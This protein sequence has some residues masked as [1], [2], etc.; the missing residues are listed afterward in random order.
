MNREELITQIKAF[1]QI[2]LIIL[3]RNARPRVGVSRM[4]TKQQQ[5]GYL[6]HLVEIYAL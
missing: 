3:K 1:R 4:K 6:I 2:I 5:N